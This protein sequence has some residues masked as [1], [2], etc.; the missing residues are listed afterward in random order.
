M[1]EKKRN[2]VASSPDGTT[3]RMQLLG[4]AMLLLPR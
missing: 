1:N 4:F 3:A 2:A